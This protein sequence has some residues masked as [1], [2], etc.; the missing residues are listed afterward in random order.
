M[1]PA[2]RRATEPNILCNDKNSRRAS[3]AAQEM[4]NSFKISFFS[5]S[6]WKLEAKLFWKQKILVTVCVAM[7]FIHS[8]FTNLAYY[9]H[10]QGPRLKDTGFELIPIITPELSVVSEFLFFF[11][12]TVS[13]MTLFSTFCYRRP[14]VYFVC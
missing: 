11:I 5:L 13:C 2:G 4:I 8:S 1:L 6:R 14:P 3:Q 12:L 9:R 7:Q 10:T